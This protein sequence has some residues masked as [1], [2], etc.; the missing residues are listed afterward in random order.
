MPPYARNCEYVFTCQKLLYWYVSGYAHVNACAYEIVTDVAKTLRVCSSILCYITIPQVRFLKRG[1]HVH[2]YVNILHVCLAHLA[3]AH[4]QSTRLH[5]CLE[6]CSRKSPWQ[7]TE[8]KWPSY[9]IGGSQC[10]AP[11]SAT[12]YVRKKSPEQMHVATTYIRI[13]R[14]LYLHV[15]INKG[16]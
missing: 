6:G 1:F 9:S 7:A 10:F 3:L 13:Q 2:I 12:W 16:V 8:S 15:R 4:P 11:T 5:K 14:V